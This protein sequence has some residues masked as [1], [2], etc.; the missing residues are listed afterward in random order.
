MSIQFL[1][2]Q[3]N[4]IIDLQEQFEGYCNTLPVFDSNSAN[5]HINLIKSYLLPILVN[6]RHIEPTVVKKANQL[7]SFKFGDVQLLI[8]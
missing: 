6:E 5:H 4:K 3:K 1:Q 2:M 7:V 8:L